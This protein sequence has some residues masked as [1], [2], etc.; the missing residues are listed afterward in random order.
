MNT[1][2]FGNETS[3]AASLMRRHDSAPFK[4]LHSVDWYIHPAPIND[5]IHCNSLT[6]LFN[7]SERAMIGTTLIS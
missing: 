2:Q 5:I 1:S 3:I 6:F 7:V 4:A